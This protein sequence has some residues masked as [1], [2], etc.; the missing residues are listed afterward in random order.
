VSESL[1]LLLIMLISIFTASTFYFILIYYNTSKH[2][3]K[4]VKKQPTK[5]GFDPQTIE[6]LKNTLIG[7]EEIQNLEEII[8]RLRILRK[9]A[10]EILNDSGGS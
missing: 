10:E 9:E 2:F 6:R 4:R 5:H 1:T 7:R 8:H 3:E